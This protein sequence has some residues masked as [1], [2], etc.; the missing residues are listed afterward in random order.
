MNVD[1]VDKRFYLL[2]VPLEQHSDNIFIIPW[3]GEKYFT[4][5]DAH[6]LHEKSAK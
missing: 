3:D 4:P 6:Y 2:L 1:N 5:L